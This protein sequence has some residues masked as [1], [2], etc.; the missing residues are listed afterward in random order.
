MGRRET[1]APAG[2]SAGDSMSRS[3]DYFFSLV[4]PWAYL[5]HAEFLRVASLVNATI[6]YRPVPLG[7]LFPES[8]GLP[9]AKRHPLRQAYRLVELQRWREKRNIPLVLQ[10]KFWPFDV[11]LADRLTIAVAQ[12]HP[13]AAGV[14]AA[15]AFRAVWVEEQNLAE[16]NVLKDILAS[17]EIGDETLL[18]LA[19]SDETATVYQNNLAAA[20]AHGAFGSPC[21]VVDGEVF[22]GQDRLDMLSDMLTS[23]REAFVSATGATA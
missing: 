14:F 23:G 19:R 3:I 1:R 4:S 6:N 17:A 21:Y 13:E 20:L 18:G 10:P 16:E 12:R 2:L 9:L 5:G 15:L 7:K 8:G 11:E 22:W